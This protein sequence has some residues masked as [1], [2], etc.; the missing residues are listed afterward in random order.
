MS[1]GMVIRH[2]CIL[3]NRASHPPHLF[4]RLKVS[5]FRERC[6]ETIKEV[7]G[8]DRD[9]IIMRLAELVASI[10]DGHGYVDVAADATKFR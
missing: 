2:Q 6:A 8:L 10:G 5:T 1:S 4:H 3:Q 7:P 9:A